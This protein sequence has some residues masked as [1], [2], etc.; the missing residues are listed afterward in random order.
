M[1]PVPSEVFQRPCVE[2]NDDQ[3]GT[4]CISPTPSIG[5][6]LF[7]RDNLHYR[8]PVCSLLL[9][10]P[11]N[12]WRLVQQH[13]DLCTPTRMKVT[14][15]GKVTIQFR[16][17]LMPCTPTQWLGGFVSTSLAAIRRQ[18]PS[19]VHLQNAEKEREGRNIPETNPDYPKPPK[20]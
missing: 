12:N 4:S 2:P 15:T 17:E 9:V 5:Y 16:H 3:T 1:K 20:K 19:Q 14:E 6:F 13:I 11:K 18:P 8:K 10:E 7:F